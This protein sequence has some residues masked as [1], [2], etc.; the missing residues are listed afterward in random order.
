MWLPLSS[1]LTG[2]INS[3]ESISSSFS[4]ILSIVRTTFASYLNRGV[5]DTVFFDEVLV[6]KVGNYFFVDEKC[7]S[8]KLIS[9]FD[10]S[11][12]G[13]GREVSAL[14]IYSSAF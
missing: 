13:F 1:P 12:W 2:E 4:V 8:Y 14:N 10:R 11:G 6:S 7:V 5:T 9:L 3:S